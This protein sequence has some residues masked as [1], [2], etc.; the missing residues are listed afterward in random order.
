MQQ[1]SIS[2]AVEHAW[3]RPAA[4]P[5]QEL[6][7]VLL[8]RWASAVLLQR[9][10]DRLKVEGEELL[11]VRTDL[12][13]CFSATF[14]HPASALRFLDEVRV[15]GLDDRWPDVLALAGDY[16]LEGRT[17]GMGLCGSRNL[18][19]LVVQFAD[20]TLCCMRPRGEVCFVFQ[21]ETAGVANGPIWTSVPQVASSAVVP[22]ITE[23]R[24]RILAGWT[25]GHSRWAVAIDVDGMEPRFLAGMDRKGDPMAE[26][27][28]ATIIAATVQPMDLLVRRS[29]SQAA[30]RRDGERA[31]R[32]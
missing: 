5:T 1:V 23:V 9:A 31:M 7:E 22:P 18:P 26:S 10:I 24:N 17:S 27:A 30:P 12:A 15:C 28:V 16:E 19:P 25:P 4:V 11:S 29:A 8:D 32:G 14:P 2:Q 21:E 3:R 13:R 6:R 20:E